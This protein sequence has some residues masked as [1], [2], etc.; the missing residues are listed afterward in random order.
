MFFG[1][2]A[3]SHVL[4]FR[5]YKNLS[6]AFKAP[7][8]D[9]NRAATLQKAL[10][11]AMSVPFE[12]CEKCR[13]AAKLCVPLCDKGNTNLITDV[14]DAAL[15]LKCAFQSAVLNVEINLKSMKDEK[16]ACRTKEALKAMEKEISDITHDV[17]GKVDKFLK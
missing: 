10:K 15:M 3:Y 9:G 17:S 4:L 11:E 7:K 13:E 2:A 12:V 14:G 16:F 8:D 1:V 6:E 5:A